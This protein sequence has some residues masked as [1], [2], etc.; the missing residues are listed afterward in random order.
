MCSRVASHSC[1]PSTPCAGSREPFP[2]TQQSS[3]TPLPPSQPSLVPFPTECLPLFPQPNST[4]DAPPSTSKS[5]QKTPS[6]RRWL[7]APPG[8]VCVSSN[9]TYILPG[10]LATSALVLLISPVIK[11]GFYP[12][13]HA[14]MPADLG[15]NA[16]SGVNRNRE[17]TLCSRS[18]QEG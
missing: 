16:S 8:R 13:W 2:T 9:T 15:S 11:G 5:I 6:W 12:W 3:C 14:R 10:I 1:P 18:S 4:C 7:Q 17:F